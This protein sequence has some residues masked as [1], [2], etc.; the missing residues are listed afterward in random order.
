MVSL[1]LMKKDVLYEIVPRWNLQKFT[2]FGGF[3]LLIKK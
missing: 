1:Y 3:I 2:K